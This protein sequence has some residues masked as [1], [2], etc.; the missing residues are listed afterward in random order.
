MENGGLI[1]APELCEDDDEV[2][3]EWAAQP[4]GTF[5]LQHASCLPAIRGMASNLEGL[6]LTF[7]DDDDSPQDG[8]SKRHLHLQPDAASSGFRAGAAVAGT[9]STK[10]GKLED[11]QETM[12]MDSSELE[13]GPGALSQPASKRIKIDVLWGGSSRSDAALQSN[14]ASRTQL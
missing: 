4:D 10:S 2:H 8:S 14:P 9:S 7:G 6:G 5:M 1:R 13:R 12:D 3:E 11:S